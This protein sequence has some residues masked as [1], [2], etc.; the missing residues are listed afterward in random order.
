MLQFGDDQVVMAERKEDLEYMCR[1]LQEEYSKWSLT[2]SI[3][4]TK[5][6][7][8]DTD[9]NYL[10]V[11]NGDIITGFTEYRYLGSIFTKDGRYTK[12]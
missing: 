6:M 9:T 3:S 8:L 10:E 12:I 7:S 11:D 1:K 2:M 4:K 5:Y